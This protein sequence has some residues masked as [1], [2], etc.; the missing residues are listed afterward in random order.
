[1]FLDITHEMEWASK[2]NDGRLQLA[3]PKSRGACPMFAVGRWIELKPDS[4]LMWK[5]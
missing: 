3:G 5:A 2:L 1:M 4:L